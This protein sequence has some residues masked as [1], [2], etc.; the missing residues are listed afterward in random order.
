MV[1]APGRGP[2]GLTRDARLIV[3]VQGLRAFAYGVGSVLIGVS[4][5][6]SALS[7]TEV[8]VVFACILLGAAITSF[9][10]GHYGDRIGR[11]TAYRVLLIVMGMAGTVFALTETCRC[12]SW[13]R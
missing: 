6:H 1:Q 9:G 5:A 12:C 4:L 3:T 10:L 8:G 11:R 7:G 13:P 2:A